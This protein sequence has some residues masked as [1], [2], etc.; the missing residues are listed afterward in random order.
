MTMVNSGFKGLKIA[1]TLYVITVAYTPYVTPNG[2]TLCQ[3][4]RQYLLTSKVSRYC[5]LALYDR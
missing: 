5:L 2:V 4:K 3:A 1:G